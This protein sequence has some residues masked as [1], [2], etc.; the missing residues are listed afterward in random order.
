[1]K[2]VLMLYV[3]IVA[4][5]RGVR[6]IRANDK[7]PSHARKLSCVTTLL[8]CNPPG[9]VNVPIPNIPNPFAAP[10]I[11][12]PTTAAPRPPGNSAGG[13]AGGSGIPK[14]KDNPVIARAP[15]G[16]GN[17]NCGTSN[18]KSCAFT[19]EN[20]GKPYR[21]S[22]DNGGGKYDVV[23]TQNCDR[24][25]HHPCC[26]RKN[27]EWDTMEYCDGTAQCCKN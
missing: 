5:V 10:K 14:W 23:N 8:G 21:N 16:Q 4:S 15:P 19:A 13:S 20:S 1:M 24:A 27:G 11:T 6:D 22:G 18:T 3:V 9:A 26:H 25:T 12:Q 17:V 2:I 7:P